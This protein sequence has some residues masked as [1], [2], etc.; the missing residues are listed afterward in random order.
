MHNPIARFL[1]TASLIK[2]RELNAVASSFL[3][4]VILM[5]AYYILRPVR[6]AMASDWTDAEVSW[7]WTLNFFISTAVVAFYG[8]A[9]S[10]FRY[11]VLVPATYGMFAASFV[12]FYTLATLYADRTLVDKAFYV[13][14]SVFSLF[15]I[16]VFGVL[17]QSYLLK[18]SQAGC[19]VSLPQAQASVVCWARLCRHFFRH[20]W[21]PIT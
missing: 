6:D 14:V 7:L 19:S 8:I 16:C 9:V 5:S 17:C 18:N 15:H 4:V 13:W 2:S 20:R 11:R 10:R 12:T 1:K 21:V 3:F